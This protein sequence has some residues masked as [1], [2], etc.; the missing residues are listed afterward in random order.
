MEKEELKKHE[1]YMQKCIA[2]GQIAKEKGESPVGSIVVLNGEII[3]QGI[4]AVKSNNDLTFHAEVEA[5]RDATQHL[6]KRDLTNCILYTTHEPCLMCSYI[7]RQMKVNTI[8]WGIS[9][10]EIGGQNSEYPILND[11]KI[12]N[13][14]FPPTIITGV[15]EEE[16][17]KLHD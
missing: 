11:T 10:K 6:G 1:F 17:L 7:I 3:G 9:I 4:E 14:S 5:I 13:W 16:C 12:Q 2:L 8:V 15:L